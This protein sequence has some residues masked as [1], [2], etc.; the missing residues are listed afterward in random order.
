MYFW[1]IENLKSDLGNGVLPITE[2]FKY[3]L[4]HA[5]LYGL[6]TIPFPTNNFFDMLNG[7]IMTLIMLIGTYYIYRCNGAAAGQYLLD[8]YISL[9]FVVSV[10]FVVLIVIPSVF[11][12]MTIYQV[13]AE[14]PEQTTWPDVVFM[15]LV[16][17]IFYYLLGKHIRDVR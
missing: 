6:A 15:T 2:Q 17:L 10:R 7:A 1:K 4:A 14:L 11:C 13:I 12:Y 5:G 3:L 16:T 9:S 8:R